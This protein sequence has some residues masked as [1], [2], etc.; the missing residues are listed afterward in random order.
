MVKAAS[1][2]NYFM[3]C[4]QRKGLGLAINIYDVYTV[5]LAGKSPNIRSYTVYIYDY[6]QTY[7]GRVHASGKQAH[8]L[9]S[10]PDRPSFCYT[11]YS[12]SYKAQRTETPKQPMAVHLPGLQPSL[13]EEEMHFNIPLQKIKTCKRAPTWNQLVFGEHNLRPSTH[14]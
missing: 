4:T 10:G 6:G 5:F 7:K 1:C 13:T 2:L 11:R 14:L 8:K 3:K 9:V 12:I